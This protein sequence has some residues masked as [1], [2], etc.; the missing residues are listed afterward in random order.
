M[1]TVSVG[2]LPSDAV[3]RSFFHAGSSS[4]AFYVACVS[5]RGFCLIVCTAIS[6]LI[7]TAA[8]AQA[9]AGPAE[10]QSQQSLPVGYAPTQT[11]DPQVRDRLYEELQRDVAILDRQLG[12][13]KRVVQLVSPSVVHVEATPL[14]QYRFRREVEEAGSGVIVQLHGRNYVLTNRHV[15]KHSDAE[16]IRLEL[17]DG[18]QLQPTSI[19]SD[20]ETDIA[21]L[22]VDGADLTPARIGNSDAAEIGE[23]VMAFGSPF[24]LRQS[25]TRGIIS[26]KGRSNLDLGDGGVDFQNFFQTDAAINP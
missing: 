24:N 2:R 23:I 6:M 8:S 10:L 16:H 4:V 12:I 26:A 19:L 1:P 13:Y 9:P 21:V 3:R 20:R 14:P 11:H 25:V 18:R 5:K 22:A 7:A 17:A 15:I